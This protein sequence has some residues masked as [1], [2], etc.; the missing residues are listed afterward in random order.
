MISNLNHNY[1]RDYDAISAESQALIVKLRDLNEDIGVKT[2][3]YNSK[4]Q[5]IFE[6]WDSE[7]SAFSGNLDETEKDLLELERAVNESL[8][9]A[10]I[11]FIDDEGILAEIDQD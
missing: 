6:N 2:N 10:M 11:E 4:V 3:Q 5:S 9:T 8:D 7:V 1:Q